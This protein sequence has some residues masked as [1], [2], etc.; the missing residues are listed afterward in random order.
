M[1]QRLEVSEAELED[2]RSDLLKKA[3]ISEKL[4]RASRGSLNVFASA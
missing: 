2:L 4:R 3:M 1:L